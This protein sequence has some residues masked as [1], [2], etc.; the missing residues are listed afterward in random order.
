MRGVRRGSSLLLVCFCASGLFLGASFLGESSATAS[1][2][3]SGLEGQVERM[4]EVR[5]TMTKGLM[6]RGREIKYGLERAKDEVEELI[7]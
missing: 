7:P 1:A 3:G 2:G 6:N 5:Q 4:I